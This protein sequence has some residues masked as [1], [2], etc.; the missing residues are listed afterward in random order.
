MT[1]AA[2]SLHGAKRKG[3]RTDKDLAD[4]SAGGKA[5]DVLPHGGVAGHEVEG[6]A[7]LA[8]AAGGVDAEPGAEAGGGEPGAGDEVQAR[9]EGAHDVVG[10]HHLGA[11]VGPEG[12]E[13][14]VLGAVG[15]AVEEEVDAEQEEPPG[16]VGAVGGAGVAAAARVEGEDG[17]AGSDGGDDE[18]LVQ[19]VPPAEDGDVQEHDGEELAALG[20][21]E[22]D[23]V[24]VGERGVAERAGEAARGGHQGQGREDAGRRHDWRHRAARRRRGHQ[25]DAPDRGGEQGLYRVE[26]DGEA[27]DLWLVGRPVRRRRELLLQVGP[28]QAVVVSRFS[29]HPSEAKKKEEDFG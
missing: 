27:P 13:D 16:G 23:V 9:D 11:R 22:G 24:D 21:E 28:R 1:L 8:C 12:L 15:E 26:E 5:E 6:G 4:G 29:R 14:V 20:E 3:G 19:G 25:V 18:V 7:H 17:D 10:A 2:G